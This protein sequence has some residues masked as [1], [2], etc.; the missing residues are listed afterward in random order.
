MAKIRLKNPKKLLSAVVKLIIIIVVIIAAILLVKH[1]AGNSVKKEI[2][3]LENQ[4][5]T[6]INKEIVA[7]KGDDAY[8]LNTLNP[9][10][11]LQFKVVYQLSLIHI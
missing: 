1:F 2:E 8:T 4:K 7:Y 9:G 6:I 5:I 3:K 11:V 10:D